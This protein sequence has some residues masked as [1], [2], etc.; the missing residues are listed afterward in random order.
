MSSPAVPVDRDRL[1]SL[2]DAERSTY[3]ASHP[4]SAELYAEAEHLF[5]RVPMT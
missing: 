1:T 3:A 5:G 2:V 4:R